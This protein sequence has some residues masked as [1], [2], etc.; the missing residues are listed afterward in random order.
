MTSLGQIRQIAVSA[1]DLDASI[2]FYRDV[3]GAAFIARY[4]PSEIAFFD[5]EGV[6]LLL[7]GSAFASSPIYFW[8]DDID[9]TH[10][11]LTGAS[12]QF[13]SEPHVIFPD[14]AE[15]FGPAGEEEWMALFRDPANNV[16]APATRKRAANQTGAG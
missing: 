14:E 12:V 13:D 4:D 5:F 10:A 15:T 7:E 3:L 2:S 16:L 8:V 6:R 11:A 9:E 1:P